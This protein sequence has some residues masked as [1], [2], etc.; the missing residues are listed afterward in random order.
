M[1]FEWHIKK[2]KS[3][4]E[5]HRVSFEEA[6]TVFEDPLQVHYPDNAH[7]FGE[8]RFICLGISDQGRLLMMAYTETTPDT[9]RIITAREMTRREQEAYESQSDLT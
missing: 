1:P 5:K 6:A 2:A 4:L 7:S 8:Q 3:N 9:I